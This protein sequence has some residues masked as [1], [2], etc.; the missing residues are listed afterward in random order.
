MV[1]NYFTTNLLKNYNMI[2]GNEAYFGVP[3]N[4]PAL[5]NKNKELLQ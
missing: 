5:I 3:N 4:F 2:H 1:V